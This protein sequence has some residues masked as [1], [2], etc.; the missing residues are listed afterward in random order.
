MTTPLVSTD[1]TFKDDGTENKTRTA[2]SADSANLVIENCVFD[3]A[4]GI[5]NAFE[6]SYNVATIESL[7][8][9]NCVFKKEA[10]SNNFI[11][12][13]KFV[14]G[15]TVLI[16]NCT[17]EQG[18]NTNSIRFSNLDNTHVTVTIKDC[19]FSSENVTWP[20][21]ILFQD[22]TTD[23]T[24]DMSLITV[25]IINLT[26]MD[27]SKVYKDNEGTGVD[28]IWYTYNTETEPV[29]NFA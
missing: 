3:G 1:C 12:M 29:V 6:S 23:K 2:V 14:D 19:K 8:I 7:V 20:G 24:E 10:A 13:Y 22:P 18:D 4:G 9:R 21:F 25:N 5:Y 27:G 28:K 16:E 26:N 11:S 17:F 15:A